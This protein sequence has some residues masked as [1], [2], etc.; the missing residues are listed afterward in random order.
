M[1][2]VWEKVDDEGECNEDN[3]KKIFHKLTASNPFTNSEL[4]EHINTY[5]DEGKEVMR[6]EGTL[7][8]L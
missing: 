3:F 6:S 7:Y 8:R 2:P 5:C 4:D 1:F